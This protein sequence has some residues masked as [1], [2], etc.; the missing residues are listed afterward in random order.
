M[1]FAIGL[2]FDASVA[3]YLALPSFAAAIFSGA[4]KPDRYANRVRAC[5]MVF[6]L[7]ISAFVF[8]VNYLFINEFSDNFNH[9]VFGAVY[10]DFPAV[11]KSM[12]KEYRLFL[13]FSTAI[14]LLSGLSYGGV[15]FLRQGFTSKAFI[16][17]D[18]RTPAVKILTTVALIFVFVI[19]VRGSVGSR[20]VQL[21][22]AAVTRDEFLNKLILNPYFAFKYAVQQ[23]QKLTHAKGIE[24]Y[25][26]DG[27][28]QTAAKLFFNTPNM[29]PSLDDYM[30]KSAK[31]SSGVR[32]RHIFFIVMESLD[33]WSLLEQ[34]LSFDLL[35]NV[36]KLGKQGILVTSFLP[37][38][39]ST[40]TS[41][42]A[43]ITGLPDAGVYTNF[44]PSAR[45]PFPTS[46]APQ[47][48]NL[49]YTTHL[50]YGGYLS[51]Q[52]IGDFCKAQGFDRIFGGGQM[53]KWQNREWGVGDDILFQ[54]ILDTLTDETPTFN[55][56]L[57]TSYHSPYDLPVYQEGFPYQT[58]PKDLE[59]LYDKD[60]PLSVFGHLW[61]T[62]KLLGEF[63]RKTENK[64]P[65]T[66]FAITGDH[67][68]R[69]HIRAKP[70][71]YEQASVPL[72]LYGRGII[73]P[74][75]AVLAGSHLDIM[76]TLIELSAP[77]DFSY[78][79]MGT[80]L[81]DSSRRNLGF[82]KNLVITEGYI[83]DGGGEMQRLPF[84]G[85]HLDE[86]GKDPLSKLLNSYQ[87]IAWW[88]IMKGTAAI[89]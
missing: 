46:L 83:I 25:L 64:L 10:D 8:V 54:F 50:F 22:D 52:K 66:V 35:P 48:E 76:P 20:P 73:K 37:A 19:F 12:W 72:A 70:S 32:P 67:W 80:D 75:D 40:M 23:H 33:S 62:D 17:N 3:G 69:K 42:A 63:I 57:T 27:D 26:P 82:G 56:I 87:G 71:L 45:K 36:K 4:V 74:A 44:Q 9:W 43:I 85:R 38:S 2:R 41:L 24:E 5:V 15:R 79:S 11:V 65:G 39:S 84:A 81:F 31:G 53:G 18:F 6:F 60:V 1:A 7:T 29:L 86:P 30:K 21:K 47:F 78:F 28:I 77:K 88:R 59:A 14:V 61:Y 58:I 49:G 89:F 16:Q 51:W 68:S 55:L 13:F 34:Y